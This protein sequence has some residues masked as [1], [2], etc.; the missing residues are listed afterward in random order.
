MYFG[1]NALINQGF[2]EKTRIQ[3][4]RG[5]KGRALNGFW[6][7]GK[8]FGFSSEQVPNADDPDRPRYAI[9]IDEVEAKIVRRI[10][11]EARDG[12]GLKQIA[13]RLNDEGVPAPHDGGKKGRKGNKFGRGWLHS[14]VHYM[15]SNERYI[16]RFTWNK[17]KWVKQPGKKQRK[18]IDRPQEEW[19]VRDMPELA[20]IDRELWDDVRRRFNRQGKGRARPAGVGQHGRAL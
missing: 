20:I 18:K 12:I 7:G 3:T 6:T 15:L 11:R 5:M 8:V 4:H 17:V 2:V 10:F 9:K 14:T 16:G 1:M 19:I 13:S